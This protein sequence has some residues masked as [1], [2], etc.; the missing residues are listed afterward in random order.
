MIRGRGLTLT[1]ECILTGGWRGRRGG[2]LRGSW[3]DWSEELRLQCMMTVTAAE[4]LDANH[5]YWRL[6]MCCQQVRRECW[7][8]ETSVTVGAV[9]PA[10]SRIVTWQPWVRPVSCSSPRWTHC[11][12]TWPAWYSSW[13]RDH[14]TAAP[15]KT[16]LHSPGL[17]TTMS[18]RPV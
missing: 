13:V 7:E 10:R 1:T 6:A 12:G 17:V 2:W 14:D 16:L 15:V 4:V 18:W 9:S 3:G 11:P 8:V 5:N